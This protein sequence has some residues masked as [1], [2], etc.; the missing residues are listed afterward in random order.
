MNRGQ[1]VVVVV[2]F[3]LA[4]SAVGLWLTQW[5]AGVGWVGYAPMSE[6][7]FSPVVGVHP[8]V[9]LGIWLALTAVWTGTSVWLLR[10]ADRSKSA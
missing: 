7:P 2:G 6:A 3:G 4:L 1:R 5:N 10:S 9:R 8:W